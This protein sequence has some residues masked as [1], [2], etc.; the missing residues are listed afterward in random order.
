MTNTAGKLFGAIGQGGHQVGFTTPR[1]PECSMDSRRF[2]QSML[3]KKQ[4]L[5]QRS[6]Q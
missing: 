3:E 1:A 5:Q 4:Q 2:G 6:P